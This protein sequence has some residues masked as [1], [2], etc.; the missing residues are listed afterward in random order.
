[1]YDPRD[2]LCLGK[3]ALPQLTVDVKTYDRNTGVILPHGK[4]TV[5]ISVALHTSD[6]GFK[7]LRDTK[8][9]ALSC[10]L[11]VAIKI[12]T[13]FSF[14]CEINLS[15]ISLAEMNGTLVPYLHADEPKSLPVSLIKPNGHNVQI[16]ASVLGVL[17]L[18]YGMV[19][20]RSVVRRGGLYLAVLP[21][22]CGAVADMLFFSIWLSI[23]HAMAAELSTFGLTLPPSKQEEKV[24]KAFIYTAVSLKLVKAAWVNWNQCRCDIFFLDWSEYNSPWKDAPVSDNSSNWKICSLAK[25][26]SVM[27]TKRRVSPGY[28]IPLALVI[29]RIMDPWYSHFPASDGYR[30]GITALAWWSSYIAVLLS[31]WLKDRFLGSPASVLPNTCSGVGI[32]LLVFQEEYHAHYVHGRNDQSKELRS[33]MVG[34]QASCRIVCSPQLRAVY[35]Q[36]STSET[37]G[38]LGLNET[39]QTVLSKF[40]A[41]FF[42]RALDGL[43]WVASERTILERLFDIELTT[44]EAGTTSTLLY[45][46]NEPS[47]FAVTWWGEEWTLCTL[48]AMIFSCV[49]IAAND[50]LL[51]AVI[52]LTLWQEIFFREPQLTCKDLQST[53]R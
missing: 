50:V 26:W 34:Q 15:E 43:S 32:S 37:A 1:M 29:L 42:E 39:K 20:Y 28:V 14:D 23:L 13:D 7:Y 36:L 17:S 46:D 31:R 19:Q 9:K 33:T 51:A 11:P 40:F 8:R 35:K 16:W 47:C 22:L 6:G 2:H 53:N 49:Y 10:Y 52:T 21:I 41:A 44:R 30:W 4:D 18:L 3:K 24:I 25:E 27:Q 48:D 38:H 45:D 5:F 12:G